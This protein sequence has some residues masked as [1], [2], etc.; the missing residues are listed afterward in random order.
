M[1]NIFIRKLIV[2]LKTYLQICF[3]NIEYIPR[4]LLYYIWVL[5]KYIIMIEGHYNN[6]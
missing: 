4:N 2:L 5:M 1:L 3:P 6:L